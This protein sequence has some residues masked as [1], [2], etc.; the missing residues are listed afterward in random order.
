VLQQQVERQFSN[1][2][3]H[4]QGDGYVSTSGQQENTGMSQIQHECRAKDRERKRKSRTRMTENE[5]GGLK[6][7]R[8]LKRAHICQEINP[9]RRLKSAKVSEEEHQQFIEERCQRRA[10]LPEE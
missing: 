4:H 5:N 1:F 7:E 10:Q 2:P 8:R 9:E 3:Q 6:E